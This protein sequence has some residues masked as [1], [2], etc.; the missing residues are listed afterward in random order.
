M[1][2]KHTKN[3]RRASTTAQNL[4][5]ST[6]RP[7]RRHS[8][9]TTST[10]TSELSYTEP[11]IDN[12]ELLAPPQRLEKEVDV[13]ALEEGGC[14]D[15][16]KT[17]AMMS[18]RLDAQLGGYTPDC[19]TKELKYLSYAKVLRDRGITHPMRYSNTRMDA[20][21]FAMPERYPL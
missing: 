13:T 17:F 18:P 6:N 4:H 15:G 5:I 11:V 8:E 12:V 1:V 14:K 21:G 7:E 19:G 2:K 10:K 3:R 9:A 16:K 20:R